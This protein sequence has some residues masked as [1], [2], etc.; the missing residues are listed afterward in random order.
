MSFSSNT[1]K[2][3]SPLDVHRAT[4]KMNSMRGTGWERCKNNFKKKNPVKGAFYGGA[5]IALA[6]V[7]GGVGA[8]SGLIGA[9][10]KRN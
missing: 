3:K 1:S 2:D 7:T 6:V 9:F 4:R 8:I 10:S 5:T